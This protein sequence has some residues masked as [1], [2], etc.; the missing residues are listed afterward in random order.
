MKIE[1][2]VM[3]VKEGKAWGIIFNYGHLPSYSYG[4]V[5]LN[6]ACIYDPEFCKHPEDVTYLDSPYL[7]EL[8]KGTIVHVE[9]RT[10][11]ILKA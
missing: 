3:V 4:W 6:D 2:G 8:R 1:A 5:T 9:L 11:V 10:E 7:S